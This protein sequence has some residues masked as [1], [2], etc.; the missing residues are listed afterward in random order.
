MLQISCPWCGPRDEIEFRWG[1]EAHVHRPKP[2]VS[3]QVWT[4]YLFY[5]DNPKGV[6]LERWHHESGCR[7]WFNLA[8]NTASHEVLATYALDAPRPEVP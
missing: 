7:R 2:D 8:R 1:G 3:D 5:K 4:E 6:G